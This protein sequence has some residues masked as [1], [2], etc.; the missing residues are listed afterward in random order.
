MG[1]QSE[2][3]AIHFGREQVM[4][5]LRESLGVALRPRSA[6]IAGLLVP[7]FGYVPALRGGSLAIAD[8][9]G[10]PTPFSG[11]EIELGRSTLVLPGLALVFV[12][13]WIR[14]QAQMTAG[15]II[16]ADRISGRLDRPGSSGRLSLSRIMKSGDKAAMDCFGILAA[17][18]LLGITAIVVLLTV[19]SSAALAANAWLPQVEPFLWILFGFTAL[20]VGTFLTMVEVLTH[21]ALMSNVHNRRGVVSALQHA[22]RLMRVNSAAATRAGLGHFA[23]LAGVVLAQLVVGQVLGISSGLLATL[24][25]IAIAG[26]GGIARISYWERVY[27]DLG[28]WRSNRPPSA[29]RSRITP[30][31]ITSVS[32]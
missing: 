11:L 18:Y 14:F 5:A 29:A 26:A 19:P 32:A 16:E 31:R 23:L 28:G 6:W 20:I 30:A 7:F 25:I 9:Q 8:G 1:N 27:D 13:L 15:L 21:L 10:A 2:A 22:W 24:A 12:F 4:G 17:R 3:S